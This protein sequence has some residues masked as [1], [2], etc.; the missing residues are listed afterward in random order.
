MAAGRVDRLATGALH[1]LARIALRV[2]SPLGARRTVAA[3]GG[4]LRAFLTLDEARAAARGLAG[5]GTC[6]S[7]ALSTIAARLPGSEVVIGSTRGPPRGSWHTRRSSGGR[8]DRR[9]QPF[10]A[11]ANSAAIIREPRLSATWTGSMLDGV[12]LS[13]GEFHASCA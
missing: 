1:G 4:R 6:L 9:R 11:G 7:R 2:Q 5:K 10:R 12:V 3:V 8:P 13:Q